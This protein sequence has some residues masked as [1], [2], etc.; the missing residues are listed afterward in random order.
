MSPVQQF[1]HALNLVAPALL[2]AVIAASLAKLVWRRDLAASGWLWLC[3]WAIAGGVLALLG[4]LVVTGRDGTMAGYGA[5]VGAIAL[6]I[7]LAGFGPLRRR[8]G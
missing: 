7:W 1:W 8:S 5:M 2:S 4:G 6:A 3:S